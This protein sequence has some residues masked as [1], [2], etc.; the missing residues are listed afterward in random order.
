MKAI[1]AFWHNSTDDEKRIHTI[2]S[3]EVDSMSRT[4]LIVAVNEL[5][6]RFL[7]LWDKVTYERTD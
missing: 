7:Q 6:R 1:L 4:E 3:K 5:E 2:I